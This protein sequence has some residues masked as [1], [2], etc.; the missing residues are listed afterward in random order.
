MLELMGV[1]WGGWRSEQ[2]RG[3]RRG[4]PVTGL[5]ARAEAQTLTALAWHEAFLPLSFR[6]V[7]PSYPAQPWADPA[8]PACPPAILQQSITH[9]HTHATWRLTGVATKGNPSLLFPSSF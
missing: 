7:E 9:I 6:A 8:G 4:G 1:W 2:G 3:G 5:Q